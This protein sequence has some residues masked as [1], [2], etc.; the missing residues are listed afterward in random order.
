MINRIERAIRISGNTIEVKVGNITR[1][2]RAV[3]YPV[4]VSEKTDGGNTEVFSGI[5]EPFRYIM[6]CTFGLLKGVSRGDTVNDGKNE[7]YVLW[8]DDIESR[9]GCYIKAC[10]RK[11]E[12][13]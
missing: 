12:K 9:L 1:V 2:G 13:E 10:L 4:R 8:V 7:Y 3:I 6:F 5:S 11:I